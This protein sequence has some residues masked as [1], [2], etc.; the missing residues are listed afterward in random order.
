MSII[1]EKNFETVVLS[2][3]WCGAP[4]TL[5]WSPKNGEVFQIGRDP[6]PKKYI[7]INIQLSA[8][9][10][11]P[12]ETKIFVLLFAM[13]KRFGVSHTQDFH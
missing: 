6:P 4:L 2:V 10:L 11:T 5:A 7:Y 8:P 3:D 9:F 13:V 12:A 1:G